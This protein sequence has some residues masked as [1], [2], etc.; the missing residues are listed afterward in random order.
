MEHYNGQ[1]YDNQFTKHVSVIK[2][3]ITEFHK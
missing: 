3:V 1:K 2:K